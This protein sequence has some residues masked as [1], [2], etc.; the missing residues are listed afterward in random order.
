MIKLSSNKAHK[1]KMEALNR[2]AKE[3]KRR[4]Y[5]VLSVNVVVTL[6]VSTIFRFM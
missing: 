3:G 5:V 2:L 4:D 6:I 1:E